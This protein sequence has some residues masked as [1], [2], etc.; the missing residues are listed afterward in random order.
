MP[1]VRYIELPLNN[2]TIPEHLF[3]SSPNSA[4]DTTD[5]SPVPPVVHPTETGNYE[6]LDGCKR[7]LRLRR[8]R[9][10]R[11]MCAVTTRSL[12]IRT[13]GLLRIILNRGRARPLAET[14]CHVRWLTEHIA[15]EEYHS[16]AAELG[17]SDTE[18]RQAHRLLDCPSFVVRAVARGALHPSVVE[19][20]QRL[21]P[22]DRRAFLRSF[23]GLRLSRQTQRELIQWLADIAATTGSSVAAILGDQPLQRILQDTGITDPQKIDKV[24]KVLFERRFPRLAAARRSWHTAAA[25]HNPDPKRVSFVPDPSFEKDRLEVRIT[26]RNPDEAHGLFSALEALPRDVWRHLVR[27]WNEDSG[28]ACR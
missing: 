17:F 18:L 8:R 16:V 21:R 23:A 12:D 24:R 2:L 4:D 13:A 7:Y 1:P 25:R 6:I 15:P 28:E 9:A 22:G 11:C 3:E 19:E 10:R 27:P 5:Q 14:L 26:L 20:F